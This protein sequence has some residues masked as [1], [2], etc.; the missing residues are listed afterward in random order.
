LKVLL[1]GGYPKYSL[2]PFS[3]LTVSGSRLRKMVDELGL[4]AE[5]F[6]LWKNRAEELDGTVS[7]ETLNRLR[8]FIAQGYTLVALGGW[9]Q[10]RLRKYDPGRKIV[11]L[12]HPASRRRVDL[13]RLKESLRLLRDKGYAI[14]LDVQSATSVD[15]ALR[16]FAPT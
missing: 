3:E 11:G 13:V 5:Y 14:V 6:D 7:D 12:P 15:P 10:E 16:E 1:I 2:E 9:V 8:E 4:E